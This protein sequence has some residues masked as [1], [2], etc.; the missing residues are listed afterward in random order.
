MPIHPG[1]DQVHQGAGAEIQDKMLV[2]AHKIPGRRSR[3]MHV[4]SGTEY[5][6]THSAD[7]SATDLR[8]YAQLIKDCLGFQQVRVGTLCANPG[9]DRTQEAFGNIR[10]VQFSQQPRHTRCGSEF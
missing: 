4:G 10:L 5:G 1:F 3:G 9:A 8:S 6:Q 2:C 7:I